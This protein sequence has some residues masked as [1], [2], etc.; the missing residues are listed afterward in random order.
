MGGVT[1]VEPAR[2]SGVTTGVTGVFGPDQLDRLEAFFAENGYATLR[3]VFDEAD[4]VGAETGS[5]SSS[6]GWPR[7]PSTAATVRSASTSRTP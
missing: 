2:S 5:P 3:G 1:A 7:A 6:A 4:L